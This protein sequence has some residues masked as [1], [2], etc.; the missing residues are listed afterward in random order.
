MASE[1]LLRGLPPA[2]WSFSTASYP[3]N[4][5]GVANMKSDYKKRFEPLEMELGDTVGMAGARA[6]KRLL[7]VQIF[8]RGRDQCYTCP[9]ELVRPPS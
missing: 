8:R 4:D 2:R 1:I 6:R 9:T 5:E 7:L 3:S